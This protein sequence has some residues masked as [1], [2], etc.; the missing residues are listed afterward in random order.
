MNAIP[1][2][3]FREEGYYIDGGIIVSP[4]GSLRSDDNMVHFAFEGKAPTQ[5]FHT[6][7]LH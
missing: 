3:T 7:T 6:T 4:D 1:N 5:K 2:L